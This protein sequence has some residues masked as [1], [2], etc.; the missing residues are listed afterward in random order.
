[1]ATILAYTAPAAGHLFPLMPGLLALRERG[2]AMHVRTGAHLVDAARAAGL[3]AEPIDPRILDVPVRDYEAA[4]DV[5]RLRRGV[6]D[7][8]SRGPLEREDLDRALAETSA[9]VVLVDINAYGAGVAAQASGLPWGI[10][11]PS[12]LPLPGAGIPP[13]GLGMRP[14]RGPL[15]WVRDRVLTHV[16]VRQY[17]RAMLPGLNPL[18]ASAGLPAL[19]TPT[20]H[21]MS[22]D[23]VLVLTGEPLEYPRTDLPEHVRFV[24]AQSWDPPA[25]TPAWL[26][27]PGDPWVLVTC[28]TEYQRDEA[29]AV[30]A[31]EA[32]RDEPV[33]VIVT[34]ADA[35]DTVELPPAANVRVERFVPHGPVLEHVAAVVC[36]A[37][38]G[39]VQKAVSAGV[40]IAAVPFGRDQPEVA[41]RV[42][43]AG[44]GVILRTKDLTP[45]RLRAT[46]RSAMAMRESARS[47]G[48][49]L[50]AAGGPEQFADAA[51]ELAGAR[52]AL[53]VA[54]GS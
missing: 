37:G 34:L 47:A 46:V 42:A 23:R 21:L 40:P 48:A 35:Y 32:L 22:A 18:R 45:E 27:E 41:R 7:M 24:G 29:L 6:H 13:Y 25:E 1:M 43:E 26:T 19:T 15:G 8:M 50:R 2:H 44:A 14:M 20:G 52:E 51:E 53:P 4:R 54:S 11:L 33:R 12:L 17:A 3:A 5:D 9:D 49:R 38:M 31:I 30:A 36:H 39:I 16:I 10:T 28:S